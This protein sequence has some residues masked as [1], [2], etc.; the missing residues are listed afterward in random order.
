MPPQECKGWKKVPLFNISF[1]VSIY[2]LLKLTGHMPNSI[3]QK[4]YHSMSL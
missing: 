3:K 1:T 4:E 2:Q